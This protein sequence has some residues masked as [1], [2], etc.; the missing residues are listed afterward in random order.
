MVGWRDS[1]AGW[2]GGL[3]VQPQ[4]F[5]QV[6]FGGLRHQP[7]CRGAVLMMAFLI[8][9]LGLVLAILVVGFEMSGNR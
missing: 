6:G 3:R 4:R 9:W 2:V 5:S 7:S 8:V 1:G